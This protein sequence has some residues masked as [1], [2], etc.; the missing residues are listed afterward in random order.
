MSVAIGWGKLANDLCDALGLKR[1]RRLTLTVSMDEAVTVH[2]ECLTEDHQLQQ[3]IKV[4]RD[5]QPVI[6]T[7]EAAQ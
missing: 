6:E 5:S 4:L 1:C 2:A 3:V 7:M